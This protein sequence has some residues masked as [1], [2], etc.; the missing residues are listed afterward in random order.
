MNRPV[1]AACRLIAPALAV[2]MLAGPLSPPAASAGGLD[3]RAPF[4]AQA[5]GGESVRTR[6]APMERLRVPATPPEQYRPPRR[7]VAPREWRY[8]PHRDRKA[9]DDPAR[10]PNDYR[11]HHRRHR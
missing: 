6:I 1:G 7:E 10:L 8:L 2:L 11:E 9:L 3:I 5:G 4:R